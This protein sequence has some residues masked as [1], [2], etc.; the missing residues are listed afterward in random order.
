VITVGSITAELHWILS[1]VPDILSIRVT[2]LLRTLA[3]LDVLKTV[4]LVLKALAVTTSGKSKIV[5]SLLE[6]T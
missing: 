1:S 5:P 2:M 4:T 3:T 6:N